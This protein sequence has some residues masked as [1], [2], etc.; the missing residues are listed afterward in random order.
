MNLLR[1][2]GQKYRPGASERGRSEASAHD[3]LGRYFD[4]RDSFRALS[5]L[6]GVMG[7][8]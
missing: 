6:S 5:T 4:L 8:S 2:C 7:N 1:T 3:G